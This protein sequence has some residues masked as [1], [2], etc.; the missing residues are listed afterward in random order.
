M[1]R[2]VEEL[3][4]SNRESSNVQAPLV[5]D[6]TVGRS[7]FVVERCQLGFLI[8]TWFS[9][10]QFANLVGVSISKVRRRMTG[11]N[12]SIRSTYC[13]LN[14]D[15]KL[16]DGYFAFKALTMWEWNKICGK[17]GIAPLFESGDG[18]CITVPLRK[19]HVTWGNLLLNPLLLIENSSL[20]HLS[21][22]F[23]PPSINIHFTWVV[24]SNF[25]WPNALQIL[26]CQILHNYTLWNFH[27]YKDNYINVTTVLVLVFP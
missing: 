11:Y 15:E 16:Y 19:G 7:K 3:Q 10:P 26:I 18:N 14:D 6:G 2:V 21:L 5:L 17:C 13:S 9:V 4:L 12:L 20:N 27:L 1:G 24:F 23:Q 25:I 22:Y 8:R